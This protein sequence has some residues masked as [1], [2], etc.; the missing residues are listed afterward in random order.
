MTSNSELTLPLSVFRLHG[1]LCMLRL[2][3]M[4][5]APIGSGYATY[6]RLRVVLDD[7]PTQ[8]RANKWHVSRSSVYRF[9]R[10]ARTGTVERQPRHGGAPRLTTDV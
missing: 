8:E 7:L 10:L 5:S 2:N 3:G 4:N 1:G 6:H 9:D